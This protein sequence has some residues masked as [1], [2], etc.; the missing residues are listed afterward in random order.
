MELIKL[1]IQISRTSHFQYLYIAVEVFKQ[2]ILLVINKF[3]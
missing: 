2:Q 1:Y 3:N